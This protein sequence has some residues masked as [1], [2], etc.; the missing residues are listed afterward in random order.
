LLSAVSSRAAPASEATPQAGR[1]SAT[2]IEPEA[3]AP[4]GSADM[5]GAVQGIQAEA[6]LDPSA[7]YVEI[8]T[9]RR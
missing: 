7:H 3:T 8:D 2:D 9:D 6:G 1:Q 4:L 5:S